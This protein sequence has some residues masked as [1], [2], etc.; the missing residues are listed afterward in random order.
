MAPGRSSSPSLGSS[1][2]GQPRHK[3]AMT[4]PS[5]LAVMPATLSHC[6]SD[7]VAHLGEVAILGNLEGRDIALMLPG[8]RDAMDT[9]DGHVLFHDR[10]PGHQQS[11]LKARAVHR[12]GPV[13]TGLTA[14]TVE[15][16]GPTPGR[17]DMPIHLDVLGRLKDVAA[18]VGDLG[19]QR[20]GDDQC[21]RDEQA[22]AKARAASTVRA[23][24]GKAVSVHFDPRL[25]DSDVKNVA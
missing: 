20:E 15:P 22:G 16:L 23:V 10:G 17:T 18:A 13:A 14:K 9:A 24:G 2:I 11:V 4:L 12:P 3:S 8:V 7:D 6:G 1:G 21:V 19:S 5:R 25:L